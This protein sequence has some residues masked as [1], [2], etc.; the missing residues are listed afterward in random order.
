MDTIPVPQ[1]E[2]KRANSTLPG[3]GKTHCGAAVT[4]QLGEIQTPTQPSVAL[5]IANTDS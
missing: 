5:L 1:N 3:V 2:Q 4:K